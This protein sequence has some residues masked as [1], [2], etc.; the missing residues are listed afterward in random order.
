MFPI[1][2]WFSVY[3]HG[4]RRYL[5]AIVVD[6]SEDVRVRERENFEHLLDYN[7]LLAGAV[8]HEIRNLCSAISVVCSNLSRACRTAKQRR[9]RC[10][11]SPC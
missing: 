4:E 9:F 1:Q 10:L 8:S 3:G 6:T 11:D 2:A 5:A 7:R